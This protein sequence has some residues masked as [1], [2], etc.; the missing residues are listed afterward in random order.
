[1]NRFKRWPKGTWMRLVSAERLRSFIGE[2][3]EKKMSQRRLARYAGKHPS[4]IN[5]LTSGRRRS[6]EPRTAELIAEALEVP[7]EI[8]FVPERTTAS[9]ASGKSRKTQAVA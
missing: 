5:H 7:L 2:E 3:P 1:M 6:C 9:S 8:L 4:F